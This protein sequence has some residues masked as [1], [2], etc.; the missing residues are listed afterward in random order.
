VAGRLFD[1]YARDLVIACAERTHDPRLFV[2]DGREVSAWITYPAR[3]LRTAEILSLY[4]LHQEALGQTEV[5]ESVSGHVADL[6]RAQPGACH[7]ISDSWAASLIPVGIV[8]AKADPDGF[9]RWI[10]EVIRWTANHYD[11]EPGLAPLESSPEVE[12]AYLFGGILEHVAVEPRRTSQIVTAVL[13]LCS[14][15]ERSDLYEL[16]IN[17]FR[18]VDVYPDVVEVGDSPDQVLRGGASVTRQVA[19]AYDHSWDASEGWMTA[20]HH[21]RSPNPYGLAIGGRSWEQLCVTAAIRDRWF[22]PTLRAILAG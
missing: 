20:E 6:V 1:Q 7:P 21:R 11:H 2:A 13:D 19:M 9:E 8:L 12:I 15:A 16:G 17:E 4:A 18:A 14:I 22:T 10:T 5:A 3:V